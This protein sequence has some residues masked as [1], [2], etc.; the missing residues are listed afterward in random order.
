MSFLLRTFTYFTLALNAFLR[1]PA[2]CW[3]RA[4]SPQAHFRHLLSRLT[5]FDNIIPKFGK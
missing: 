3:V 4:V 2:K 1:I 5:S